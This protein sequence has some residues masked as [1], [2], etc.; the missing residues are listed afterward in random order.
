[1]WPPLIRDLIM[2]VGF[3]CFASVIATSLRQASSLLAVH[4]RSLG[5]KDIYKSSSQDQN[6]L[7]IL[8]EAQSCYNTTEPQKQNPY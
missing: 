8:Q 3:W 4:P 7:D 2:S 5:L 6:R 1:M